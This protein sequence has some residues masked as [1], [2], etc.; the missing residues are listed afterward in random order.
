MEAER[1][2]RVEQLYH[3]ALKIDVAQRAV[4][5][6]EACQG[7]AELREEVESLLSYEKSAADFIET[8]A[9]DLAAKMVAQSQVEDGKTDPVVPGTILNRF[10]VIE[11]LGRGG[12][13]VVYKVEDTKLQRNVALKFLPLALVQDPRSLERFQREAHAASALNHPNICTVYDVDEYQGQPFIA[14]ELLEGQTL[15]SRIERGPL[16]TGELLE[17]AIQISD[18]LEAA[19]GR[20]IVHRDIKP[21]N[22]FVTEHAQPKILDFGLAKRQEFEAQDYPPTAGGDSVFIE[23]HNPDFTLTQTGAALGTAGYMSPEQIRGEK[24]DGRSDLFSMGLVL[25]E[26]A[27]GQRA[28]KGETAL[29]L[30]QE[31]LTRTPQPLRALNRRVPRKLERIISKAL[32]KDCLMRYQ[33][34]GELRTDLQ[35]L[36]HKLESRHSLRLWVPVSAAILALL[37]SGAIFLSIRRPQPQAPQQIKLRQLTMNSSENAVKLGVISPSGK[38]LGYVDGQGMHVKDIDSG[39]TQSVHQ[40]EALKNANVQWECCSWFPDST[41]FL[42]NAH[43]AG[44]DQS[45]WASTTTSIW[46]FSTF[47]EESHKLRDQAVAWSGSVSPDA[48]QISFGT[49]KGRL[50]EREVWLMGPNGEQ[51]HKLYEVGEKNAICCLGFLPGERRVW[52]LSSDEA[53]D[54]V[55]GRDFPSGPVS[56]LLPASETKKMGDFVWLPGGRLIYSDLCDLKSSD[57][58]CDFW[59]MSFDTRSGK[60]TEKPRRLTNWVGFSMSMPSITANGKQLAF[61]RS[62]AWGWGTSYI[63]D[64]EAGGTA[65]RNLKH[66]TLEEG[67]DAISAWTPDSRAVI[68]IKN[69]VDHYELYRRDLNGATEEPIVSNAGAHVKDVEL[70]P[71]GKWVLVHVE[72]I[73]ASPKQS[74]MRVPITGGSP[75]LIFETQVWSQI[76]CAK[77]PSNLCVVTE[78]SA[79]GKQMVVTAFDPMKGRGSELFRHDVDPFSEPAGPGPLLDLS[80]DGT[81]FAV[82]SHR[83]GPV[84]ILSLQGKLLQLIQSTDVSK[85]YSLGWTKDEKGLFVC[86]DI[87]RGAQLL[88]LDLQGNAKVLWSNEG[89]DNVCVWAESPDGRHLALYGHQQSANFWMMENF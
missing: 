34:A 77:A 53:G 56:T 79:D 25:Y 26:M 52:Y 19:H 10:R 21:S 87:E 17:L 72:R 20:G 45:A 16:P 84:E 14:M 82:A 88:H 39:A 64:L 59:T 35:A 67:D 44:E 81:R 24:L 60:V 43:P 7:D 89:G 30:Q 2:H 31:I 74:V 5:V 36:A 42:A 75:E 54:S 86:N 47:G 4:F 15:A 55:M 11:K 3:E 71:E 18:A 38:Y 46:E 1:W 6:K 37:I 33:T 40:P 12:M 61:L 9:F 51:A 76:N 78:R 68:I 49:N 50:G 69:R 13:G 57:T 73:P 8:P 23:P 58:P 28:F 70:S 41:R 63:A 32:E 66:F 65:I 22:I 85:M 48:S 80:P 62:S 83:D 27:T 29:E